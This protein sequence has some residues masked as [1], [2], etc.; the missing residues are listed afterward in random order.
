M[1]ILL[2]E[3]DEFDVTALCAVNDGEELIFGKFSTDNANDALQWATIQRTAKDVIC[4]HERE[5]VRFYAKRLRCSCLEE[6]YYRVRS[7]SKIGMCDFCCREMERKLL[8]V[9]SKCKRSQYCGRM[10]QRAHWPEHKCVCD[11]LANAQES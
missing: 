6:I 3:A 1:T 5:I 4:G 8:M 2:F 10:C 9:C 11:S 7:Q